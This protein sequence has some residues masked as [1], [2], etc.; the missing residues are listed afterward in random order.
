MKSILLVSVL[1]LFSMGDLSKSL[2]KKVDKALKKSFDTEN[3]IRERISVDGFIEER[4]DPGLL[5]Y[6]LMEEGM[7]VGYRIVTSAMG[8][9]DY[10]DYCVIYNSDLSI[11]NV[12][13]LIY[14][15]DH[16]YEIAKKSWLKQFSG[17]NG[18]GMLYGEQ[19][20]AISGATYSGSSITV[21][22]NKL[23][24]LMQSLQDEKIIQ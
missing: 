8:R 20:D 19:I 4:P 11:R 7:H 23:C 18:C 22:I 6:S 5:F 3:I 17:E 21:D 15:S 24:S 9:Y 12:E 16:G 10:F 14:R 2:E 13:V 1:F